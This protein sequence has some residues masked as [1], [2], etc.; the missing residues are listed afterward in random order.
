MLCIE[1]GLQFA[2]VAGVLPGIPEPLLTIGFFEILLQLPLLL[3]QLLG[4][5]GDVLCQ[6]IHRGVL[7]GVHLPLL[8]AQTLQRALAAGSRHRWRLCLCSFLHLL[9]GTLQLALR[10]VLIATLIGRLAAGR[11]TTTGT[12]LLRLTLCGTLPGARLRPLL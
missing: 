10:G 7:F 3:L 9:H 5:L 8:L 12:G 1:H 2:A 4:A 6:L 11:L